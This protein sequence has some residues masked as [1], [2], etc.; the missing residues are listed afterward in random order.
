[1]EQAETGRLSSG[2]AAI[3]TFHIESS[4]TKMYIVQH[5]LND[6]RATNLNEQTQ[7]PTAHP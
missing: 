5:I 3:S 7:W 6:I 2:L 1:M 4:P